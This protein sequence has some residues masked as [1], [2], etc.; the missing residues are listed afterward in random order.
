MQKHFYQ[1]PS[2]LLMCKHSIS[3]ILS[4]SKAVILSILFA[5]CCNITSIYAQ[6]KNLS[7]TIQNQSVKTALAE[8]EKVSGYDFFFNNKHVD[9]NRIVSLSANNEDIQNILNKLFEGTDVAFAIKDKKII[10]T[11]RTLSKKQKIIKISGTVVDA[12][13][14]P[15]IGA[16]IVDEIMNNGTITNV[17][18]QY[19]LNVVEDTQL[20]V[21]FLGYKTYN[22]QA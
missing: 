4:A 3:S 7:I 8:I 5:F 12:L 13:N 20:T 19:S 16:S 6:N 11:S 2:D 1:K 15:V 17:D 9:L 14:Q 10:L 21:S 22:F 18:G